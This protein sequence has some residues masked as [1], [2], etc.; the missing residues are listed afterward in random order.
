MQLQIITT[1][2]T[3]HTESTNHR[4]DNRT[5]R[6]CRFS[7][8]RFNGGWRTFRFVQIHLSVLSVKRVRSLFTT[9]VLPFTLPHSEPIHTNIHG[10]KPWQK[11]INDISLHVRETPTL[12]AWVPLGRR[13]GFIH[14]SEREN[15]KRT[16]EY[17]GWHCE[18][19]L[20]VW[21]YCGFN[22]GQCGASGRIVR[23]CPQVF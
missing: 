22:F 13:P 12:S 20:S 10:A 16:V 3:T 6:K 15:S 17:N 4:F 5:K 7:H 8:R 1:I 21:F 9:K 19:R 11:L 2:Y 18:P 14:E 23:V